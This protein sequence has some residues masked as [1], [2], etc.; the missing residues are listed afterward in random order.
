MTISP[1]TPRN[2]QEVEAQQ[3][4]RWRRP[5]PVRQAGVTSSVIVSSQMNADFLIEALWGANLTNAD[6]N[7]SMNII[8]T[9]G[10]ANT[11]N[12]T[13]V[14][15]VMPANMTDVVLGAAGILLAPNQSLVVTCSVANG[16]NFF[17]HGWDM[18]GDVQT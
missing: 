15:V 2:R 8:T 10:T 4:L 17:G 13:A 3:L 16:M 18:L 12:A 6:L 7:Y 14:N 5:I 1:L 9:G 11:A